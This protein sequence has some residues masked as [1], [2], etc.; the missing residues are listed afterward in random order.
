MELAVRKYATVLQIA[1]QERLVYRA[2]FFLSTLI[3]FLPIVTT[4]FLWGAIF[5]GA[6]GGPSS[7]AQFGGFRFDDMVAYYLLVM[8]SRAFSSMPGLGESIARE[9]REGTLKRF[10]IQP[11][12]LVNYLLCLRVAHKSVYYGVAAVPFAI[13]FFLCRRYF[14]GWP[15]PP[16]LAGYALSL[17]LAFLI[18][19][20][21]EACLGMLSFWFL[22][23]SS[24][25]MVVMSLNYFLSG[26]MVPL[27]LLPHW[28][29]TPLKLLPFQ[30]LAHFPAVVMLGKVSGADLARGLAL[31]LGWLAVLIALTRWT[32]RRGL[33]HYSAFGG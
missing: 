1:L 5:A 10:L 13:V 6:K 8:V 3:R 25:F 32:F 29:E 26:Q 2:D 21:L 15:D 33:R 14:P 11:V 27:E 9:V 30:F 22:E 19:F 4:I 23:V 16:I 31:E 24:L 17:V 20:F 12:D 18:G 7:S 28:L